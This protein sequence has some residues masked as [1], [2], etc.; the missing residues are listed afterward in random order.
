MKKAFLGICT[1]LLLGGSASFAAETSWTGKISDSMCGASHKKMEHSGKAVNDRE[2]TL[3]CSK[4]GAKY[5]FG[6]KAKVYAI[7]NQD[8]AALQEH[9]GHTVKLTGT[10][11]ADKKSIKVSKVEMPF[12]AMKKKT[13]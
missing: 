4:Q 5:V 13:A 6:S 7:E 9:A 1:F 12:G 8:L 10:M 11:S 2:C 3:A